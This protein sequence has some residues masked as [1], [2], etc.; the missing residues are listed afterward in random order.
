MDSKALRPSRSADTAAQL[1][2]SAGHSSRSVLP[3]VV[4][5]AAALALFCSSWPASPARA[6]SEPEK[7]EPIPVEGF[8]QLLP[9]GAIPALV[10][11]DFVPAADAEIP[12][13]A[14]VLGF[15]RGGKA[16]AYDLNLLNRHEVVNHGDEEGRFAAVW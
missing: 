2:D 4:G 9:R 12:D 8:E 13:D 1:P 15:A 3:G 10:D 14:W 11:P 5:C 16:Y 6:E 7:P